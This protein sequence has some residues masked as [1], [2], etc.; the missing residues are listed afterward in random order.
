MEKV[1]R[2]VGIS[3][4]ESRKFGKRK[5]LGREREAKGPGKIQI[6]VSRLRVFE[7]NGWG[8]VGKAGAFHII[9]IDFLRVNII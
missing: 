4:R 2:S 8:K 3:S 5:A 9:Y 7:K 6:L 1:Y